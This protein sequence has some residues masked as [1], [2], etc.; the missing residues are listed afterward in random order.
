MDLRPV[1][2]ILCVAQFE[3]VW[4]K[5][6]T[7]R[8]VNCA[9]RD[10]KPLY[11]RR[12]SV[13]L[14][15]WHPC[16]LLKA[17]KQGLSFLPFHRVKRFVIEQSERSVDDSAS[18]AAGQ[19]AAALPPPS[20]SQSSSSSS[21]S[22]STAPVFPTLGWK[23]LQAGRNLCPE[24][25]IGTILSLFLDGSQADGQANANFKA[26]V[27]DSKAVRL[28]K[29][30]YVGKI[31]FVRDGD[32]VF[33]AA[34]CQ[35]EMRS[36]SDYQIRFVVESSPLVSKSSTTVQRFLH[37]QC[38]CAAG[39]GPV[40]TCKHIAAVLFGLEEFSRL[41]FT[42]ETVTCTE[43]LQQWNRPHAKKI[44]PMSVPE[45]DCRKTSL[46]KELAQT[47][48][49]SRARPKH[50]AAD[51]VDPRPSSKRGKVMTRI[52][53]LLEERMSNGKVNCLA[54]AAGSTAAAAVE[55]KRRLLRAEEQ[56]SLWQRQYDGVGHASMNPGMQ[57]EVDSVDANPKTACVIDG[58]GH[59]SM[60]L[61]MQKE[62]DSVD[63]NPK[64]A[65]VIGAKISQPHSV[66]CIENFYNTI[67]VVTAEEATRIEKETRLQSGCA[68]WFH[69]RK[70]RVTATMCKDIVC[71][72]KSGFDSLVKRKLQ[73][74]FV[75]NAATRYGQEHEAAALAEYVEFRHQ[76][77]NQIFVEASGLVVSIDF[78]F[79]ACS[80]DGIVSV[81]TSTDKGLV[82]I[83]CPHRCQNTLLASVG[84]QDRSFCLS[85]NDGK[86]A[87]RQN[88]PYYYQVQM[89]L[90]VT[91]FLWADFVV[92]TPLELYIERIERDN[93]LLLAMGPR[94]EEFYMNHL[95]PALFAASQATPPEQQVT[96]FKL[97]PLTP[98]V[99]DVNRE[100]VQCSFL[101]QDYSQSSIDGRNG[102]SACT[103]IAACVVH[104]VLAGGL[105]DMDLSPQVPN[106]V[107]SNFIECIRIGNS[108]YDSAKLGGELLSVYDAIDVLQRAGLRLVIAPR[109]DIG[110]HSVKDLSMELLRL[111]SRAEEQGEYV[112]GVIVQT[113][114]TVAVSFSPNR[115]LSIFDSHG[116]GADGGALIARAGC[117]CMPEVELAAVFL[118][119]L[120]GTIC[121]GHLCLL[122]PG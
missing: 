111:A 106:S 10:G 56:K 88:H 122:L 18:V 53:A 55:K 38:S 1:E 87:L 69:Q 31:R 15:H 112:A 117:N 83:K 108:A 4:E 25:T 70:V 74:G 100:G 45:M 96:A 27:G 39:R 121:D 95:L 33:F 110:C 14:H 75:G 17:Y 109:G 79:L 102:S 11:S 94:L 13:N 72:K 40:A 85:S 114:L 84:V 65:G 12:M 57:K 99:Q 21:E 44:V 89:S 116:H 93:D 46:G 82:E 16:S 3:E 97:A 47:S 9:E 81:S 43:R 30:G 73:D 62:V 58:N 105:E 35:P 32:K 28:F 66:A 101:P 68:E 92:W 119:H 34:Q 59:A 115:V 26:V 104:T 80:P 61:G 48:R 19:C 90:L 52:N 42:K 63:A 24:F 77:G 8:E 64:T 37:S 103:V 36:S 78:P 29:A 118:S 7:S 60:N 86:L 98:Q 76:S 54:L 71:R 41:G 67:V 22:R 50:A 113:P 23:T 49:S 120:V 2:G 107:V 91:N 20:S 5:V 6:G 51:L